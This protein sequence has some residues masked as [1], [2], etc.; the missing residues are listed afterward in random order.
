M[1]NAG[2]IRTTHKRR[3]Q[4]WFGIWGVNNYYH[5]LELQAEA[6]AGASLAFTADPHVV[7]QPWGQLLDVMIGVEI[8]ISL[9][10][11]A[12]VIGIGIAFGQTSIARNATAL[13]IINLLA[14]DVIGSMLIFILRG[15]RTRFFDLERK[16]RQVAESALKEIS[17][18]VH[19]NSC[20]DVSLLGE[21]DAPPPIYPSGTH[22]WNS[23]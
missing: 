14:L 4:H 15:I 18:L 21:E 8:A 11:P 7:D 22:R 3:Q 10:P 1:Q 17:D 2:D 23:G 5:K 12:A 16:L 9:L 13:L 19:D 20:V 6:G